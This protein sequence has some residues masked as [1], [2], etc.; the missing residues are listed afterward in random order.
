MHPDLP[1]T[2][3]LLTT[4]LANMSNWHGRP[5][6]LKSAGHGRSPARSSLATNDVLRLWRFR[7]SAR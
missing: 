5:F 6:L 2:P 3:L 7:R 1:R 4:T